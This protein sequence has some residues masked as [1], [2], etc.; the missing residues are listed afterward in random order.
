MDIGISWSRCTSQ[1]PCRCRTCGRHDRHWNPWTV[2]ALAGQVVA[3]LGRPLDGLRGRPPRMDTQEEI[4]LRRAVTARLGQ[5]VE[6]GSVM[7]CPWRVG[8]EVLA[9]MAPVPGDARRE[10]GAPFLAPYA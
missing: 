9:V 1:G 10:P 3:D 5:L 7:A 8:A 6:D 2:A 4:L